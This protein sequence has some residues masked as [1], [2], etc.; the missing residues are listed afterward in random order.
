MIILTRK[1]KSSTVVSAFLVV[2]CCVP[3]IAFA[4]SNLVITEYHYKTQF[5]PNQSVTLSAVVK[6]NDVFARDASV[7][8]T[9]SR[10]TTGTSIEELTL[11]ASQTYGTTIAPG[12]AVTLS[13]T[14]LSAAGAYTVAVEALDEAGQVVQTIYAPYPI[15]V[16]AAVAGFPGAGLFLYDGNL[17]VKIRHT[18]PSLIRT[19]RD[20]GMIVGFPDHGLFIYSDSA[21]L[22]IHEAVPAVVAADTIDNIYAGFS[23]AGFFYYRNSVWNKLHS[24][25]PDILV[26]DG[27]GAAIA[28][29]AGAGL[30][31]YRDTTWT[32]LHDLTPSVISA[33]PTG[34]I[35]AGF[36][37]AGLF[38][39]SRGNGDI[40][41]DT[42]I[43]PI[44]V[45]MLINYIN[46]NTSGLTPDQVMRSD[47]L[48]LI[49]I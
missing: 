44:D 2:C 49:H 26:T 18:N 20:L 10:E 41:G 12:V 8:F 4:A 28:G 45:L 31:R 23:G 27:T 19:V 35:F 5:F 42:K 16:C 32:K 9:L 6:N 13:K 33:G 39:Y 38:R 36:P 48:S 25:S 46:N 43:T 21:W 34:V 37:G 17:W 22:K 24:L 11:T 15:N 30:F 3:A 47:I 1:L 14:W 7:R 29:F 40:N